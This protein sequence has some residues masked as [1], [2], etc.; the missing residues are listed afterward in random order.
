MWHQA[1]TQKHMRQMTAAAFSA[2][3]VIVLFDVRA[4]EP[5]PAEP[6]PAER[7]PFGEKFYPAAAPA[8]RRPLMSL[9]DRA[10]LGGPLDDAGVRVFG[11]VEAS[12]THNFDDP[13]LGLNLGRV[14][15]IEQGQP[16]LNQFDLNVERI[17]APSPTHWDLGGRVELMYGSDTRFI[18]SN[19]LFDHH[20]D[21]PTSSFL[22]GP[23]NQFDVTQAYVDVGVPLGTG[24]R[25]RAGKFLLFKQVD[26]NASV[27][28]SHS[29]T[30]GGALP[31]TLT[32]ISAL[33]ALNDQWS[34]EGGINRGWGQSLEDN[35][36]TISYHGRVR[37][38]PTERSSIALIFIT[39]PE[40]DDHDS[41]YRTAIDLVG[42]FRVTDRLTLMFDAVYG[43]QADPVDALLNPQAT[44]SDEADW[45]GFAGYAVYE[46]DERLSVAGRLEWFRDD[47][48]FV[49]VTA[50][51]QDLFEV[52]V[53]VTITPFPNDDWGR[54]LKIR[55]EVRYDWSSDDYFDGLTSDSQLTAA[56]DVILNF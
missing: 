24:L 18:H 41:A 47:E 31:F 55:P 4:A 35:N 39:G 1:R 5:A 7:S 16:L 14:F 19:G 49:P 37:Y 22:G 40:M 52:T 20:E 11:H 32:G 26:P 56:I 42:T 34:V 33:Y 12:Y 8:Q 36:G 30:F 23:E 17:V 21:D 2:L 53:G 25:V 50:V 28:Y 48:G 15:D 27:F 3:T 10:G 44:G 13:A 54:N 46:I 29:Y 9:L 45:Y 51:P 43:R 38:A 6:P